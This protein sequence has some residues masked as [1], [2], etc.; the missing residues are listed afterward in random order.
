MRN[1]RFGRSSRYFAI[2][3]SRLARRGSLGLSLTVGCLHPKEMLV[4]RPPSKRA[5]SSFQEPLICPAQTPTI[6][7]STTQRL[8]RLLAHPAERHVIMM[9]TSVILVTSLL[10]AFL[11]AVLSAM[12]ALPLPLPE[13]AMISP[14]GGAPNLGGMSLRWRDHIPPYVSFCAQLYTSAAYLF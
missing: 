10:F 12:L 11:S 7:L 14:G 6:P 13:R 9:N 3:G 2:F 8:R 5:Y 1:Q 4:S